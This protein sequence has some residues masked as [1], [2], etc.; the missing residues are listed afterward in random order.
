MQRLARIGRDMDM[1]TP[2]L[3]DLTASDRILHVHDRILLTSLLTVSIADL[4][5]DSGLRGLLEVFVTWVLALCAHRR[6]PGS[7]P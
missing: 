1:Y 5:V 3:P 7:C 2:G 6:E 4:D